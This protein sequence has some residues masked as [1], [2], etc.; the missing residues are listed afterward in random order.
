M[1]SSTSQT[2]SDPPASAIHWSNARLIPRA[3]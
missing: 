2:G 1:A 3:A